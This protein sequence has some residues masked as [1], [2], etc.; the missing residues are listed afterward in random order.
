MKHRNVWAEVERAVCGKNQKRQNL[1]ASLA[2]E[3]CMVLVELFF[4]SQ[5]SSSFFI[6]T[7]YLPYGLGY[8]DIW[9][10]TEEACDDWGILSCIIFFSHLL[11]II[12]LYV[13][14]IDIILMLIFIFCFLKFSFKIK[15]FRDASLIFYTSEMTSGKDI[16]WIKQPLLPNEAVYK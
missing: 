10:S 4:S 9:V 11:D 5:L 6:L 7:L 3:F 12:L 16:L 1:A 8:L 14:K 13:I 15:F 2:S